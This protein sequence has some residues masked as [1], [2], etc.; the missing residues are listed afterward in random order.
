MSLQMLFLTRKSGKQGIVT[1]IVLFVVEQCLRKMKLTYEY[2]LHQKSVTQKN[3]YAGAIGT[4]EGIESSKGR[5]ED[6][7][8]WSANLFCRVKINEGGLVSP[9]D[10]VLTVREERS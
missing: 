7:R 4:G 2:I 1:P 6:A 3:F 5:E 10:A 9:V 8:P